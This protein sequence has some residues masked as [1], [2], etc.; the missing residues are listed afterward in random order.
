M[1]RYLSLSTLCDVTFAGFWLSWLIT[2]HFLCIFVIKSAYY[3]APRIIPRVWDPERGHFMTKGV[4]VAFN[5]MLVSLQVRCTL[6]TVVNVLIL[7]CTQLLQIMWFSLIC[8]IAY[9][10]VIGQGADDSRSDSEG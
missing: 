5:A 7:S 6:G 1:F 10:V 9:D 8:R 4:Y 3:D 2:R